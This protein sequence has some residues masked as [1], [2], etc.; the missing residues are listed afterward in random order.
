MQIHKGT[1][2]FQSVC[3]MPQLKAAAQRGTGLVARLSDKK[4]P[5]RPRATSK[6]QASLV[7]PAL[8]GIPAQ[9]FLRYERASSDNVR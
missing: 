8:G 7:A 1:S 6:E 9:K 3:G 2:D 4:L 5:G